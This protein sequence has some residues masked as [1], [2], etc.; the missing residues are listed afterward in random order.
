[1]RRGRA[2]IITTL[3]V[4][5]LLGS[6][7][8]RISSKAEE[9][10]KSNGYTASQKTAISEA[11][12]L[13]QIA[14]DKAKQEE[15]DEI[16]IERGTLSKKAKILENKKMESITATD[17]A[18]S[19]RLKAS[20]SMQTSNGAKLSNYLKS[21][22]N[23]SSVL[24]RAVALHGGD[25]SNLCV[26]FSS[27]S[28]RRVGVAV[29]TSMCSTGNYLSYLRAHAY[30]ASYNKK[31][32]TAGSICF[33]THGTHGS[34]PTH[35]FIFMGWVNP[36][37]YTLAYVADNQ[38]NSVHVRN[39]GVT[40][41]TEAFGLFMHTVTPPAEIKGATIGYNTN[42][43]RFT[44]VTG[45]SGYEVYRATSNGSYKLILRTTAKSYYNT[46]L[47]TNSTY[48]YKVRAYR[49]LGSA[50]VYSNFTT[51][52]S[53]KSILSKPTEIKG[54][55]LGY[56]KNYIRW[57]AVAGASKYEVY[58]ATSSKG[59]YKLILSTTARSY[60]NVNLATNTTYY[61]RVRAYKIVASVKV[62][63]SY[64]ATIG[65]KPILSTP[66][67]IKGSVLSNKTN[68]IRWSSVPGASGY[69]LYRA[70]SS[71]GS[72]SLT[73]KTTTAKSYYN[74]GLVVNTIYYYKVRAYRMVGNV[75]VYSNF[76]SPVSLKTRLS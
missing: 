38:G 66:T 1:M 41:A 35:T 32:L 24:N 6:G 54:A 55:L 25:G 39:M 47:A 12:K 10:V 29:P 48:T 73:V 52:I 23:I 19:A 28:M 27:E 74:I 44:A 62:Y 9:I 57:S 56:N 18:E 75:K 34:D 63:S 22:A 31:E 20:E 70:T 53:L 37:N 14:A 64:S 76:S 36:G 69:E 65:L 13:A 8:G 17:S 4:V 5:T 61:Y 72:Y 45:A 50:R 26:Y 30:I 2:I 60:Y 15:I 16:A 42:Y 49:M 68:Y 21:A 51:P 11:S 7:I 46:G 3:A 33:T 59:T 40:D 67:G 58:R 43:I 71:K